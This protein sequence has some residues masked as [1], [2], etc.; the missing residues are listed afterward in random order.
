MEGRS[1]REAL[2]L[3]C[4]SSMP[5][6]ELADIIRVQATRG[7]IGFKES[8]VLLKMILEANGWRKTS[9]AFDFCYSLHDVTP[10][11]QETA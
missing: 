7:E 6:E 5:D 8:V 2:V 9:R 10:E 4:I 1:D 11:E 3:D